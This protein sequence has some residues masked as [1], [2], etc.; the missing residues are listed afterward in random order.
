MERH[1]MA[2]YD[3]ILQLRQQAAHNRLLQGLQN[4]LQADL[5][6]YDQAIREGD[7]NNAAFAES[8]YLQHTRELNELTGGQAAQQQYAQPQQPQSQ[9]TEAELSLIRDYPAIANDPEK[10]AVALAAARN[11]QLM[12]HSRDSAAYISGIAHACG[13]LNSDLTESNEVASP[14]EALR[15]SQSKY[16]SVDAQTYN[17]GVQR[18]AEEKRLGMRPNSQ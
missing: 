9:F 8:Q 7:T 18:L 16:G 15:I 4:Q 1:S 17:E 11:L 3:E 5:H 13:I 10:W 12:G 14:N 2:D 6:D